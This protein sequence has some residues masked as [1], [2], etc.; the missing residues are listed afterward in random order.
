MLKST[1]LIAPC[2]IRIGWAVTITS[3]ILKYCNLIRKAVNNFSDA[4]FP[5][6]PHTLHCPVSPGLKGYFEIPR[7]PAKDGL[8]SPAWFSEIAL[9]ST[10]VKT[11]RRAIIFTLFLLST[12]SA[13]K[14]ILFKVM[15]VIS[16]NIAAKPPGNIQKPRR[17]LYSTEKDYWIT[18]EL[19]WIRCVFYLT[20]S[21]SK[22][23]D[24][25]R[26]ANHTLLKWRILLFIA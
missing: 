18:I 5:P 7:I 17:V 21:G 10:G 2:F 15:S 11:I 25:L 3:L 20:I 1:R 6:K 16:A 24:V 8:Y 22:S 14:N 19:R 9:C 26:S 13:R 12:A 23:R 4:T